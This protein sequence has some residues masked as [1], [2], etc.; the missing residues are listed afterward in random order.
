[1]PFGFF[2]G[3]LCNRHV[4]EIVDRDLAVSIELATEE[5]STYSQLGDGESAYRR[6]SVQASP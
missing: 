4:V 1:M 5:K 3:S 6:G 2:Y